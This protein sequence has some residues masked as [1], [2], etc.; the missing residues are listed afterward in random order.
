MKIKIYD[1]YRTIYSDNQDNGKLVE[2]NLPVG[3]GVDT[4]RY[5]LV[6]LGIG[7]SYNVEECNSFEEACNSVT[8]LYVEAKNLGVNYDDKLLKLNEGYAELIIYF[9]DGKILNR[10]IFIEEENK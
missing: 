8:N 3:V 1:Q 2:L 4:T 9:S 10:V 6:H 7:E 5:T